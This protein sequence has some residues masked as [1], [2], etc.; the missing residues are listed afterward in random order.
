MY[1]PRCAAQNNDQTKFCRSCGIDLKTV[2]LAMNGQLAIPSESGN[3]EEKK[4]ELTQQWLKLQADGIHSAVQGM[5]IFLASVLM[6]VGLWLF[7]NKVDWMIIWL[8]FCGWLAIWGAISFATGISNLIQ[9][10]MIR[11]SI[12]I[13]AAALTAPATPSA[14]ETRRIP[15][16]API[17]EASIPS[18][19][20]EDTTTPLMKPHPHP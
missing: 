16:T 13:L 6:G 4:I 5:L 2:A 9:S 15:D 11:R 18:S 20:I 12:D 19:V 14:G 17:P 7:S 10:K 8:I 1:C 3:T